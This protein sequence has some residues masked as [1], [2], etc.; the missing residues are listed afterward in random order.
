MMWGTGDLAS[1][2]SVSGKVMEQL[3]LETISKHVKEKKMIES[4]QHGFT[5]GKSRLSALI[6]FS[7]N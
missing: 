5:K 6:A 3:T 4:C 1:L 7:V 2:T